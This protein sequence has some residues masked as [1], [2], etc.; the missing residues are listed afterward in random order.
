MNFIKNKK[1]FYVNSRDRI[2]GTDSDFI[3]KVDMPSMQNFNKICVLSI[4]L[5]KSY[6]NVQNNYNTFILEEKGVQTII[7]VPAANYNRR[8]LATGIIDLLN[9]NSPN[10]WIYDMTYPNSIVEPDDGKYTFTVTGNDAQPR[11]IFDDNGMFE[12]LGFDINSTNIFDS[13]SLKSSNVCKIQSEDVI[14]LHSN[15]SDNNGD[16]VLLELYS[17]STQSFSNIVFTCQDINVY[18]RD[19]TSKGTNTYR[20]FLTNEDN[21]RLDLNGL[22]ICFSI[23]VYE[24]SKK[25]LISPSSIL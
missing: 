2:S 4:I 16:D 24:E 1:I 9:T 8:S 14:R 25:L 13:N 23:I 22:N 19:I 5:P 21:Q 3:F 11:L 6:F 7:T 17:S 18:S 12:L 15:I 20:F 10:T